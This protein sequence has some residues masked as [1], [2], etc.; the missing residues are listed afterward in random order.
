M[1]WLARPAITAIFLLC[2]FGVPSSGRTQTSSTAPPAEVASRVP[3]ATPNE[4]VPAA[5]VSAQPT[6]NPSSNKQ[7]QY[8]VG[9]HPTPEAFPFLT[10]DNKKAA[11]ESW[12]V[13]QKDHGLLMT[14]WAKSEIRFSG[15]GTVFYPFS[16]P[17]FVTVN[18]VEN[19]LKQSH[20]KTIRC[21]CFRQRI[22][23]PVVESLLSQAREPFRFSR[24]CWCGRTVSGT[25]GHRH[26]VKPKRKSSCVVASPGF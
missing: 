17:D 12:A 22:A 1:I 4:P 6:R 26:I 25:A 8:F 13:Y 2:A 14:D 21:V 3:A 24:A 19:P 20:R 23:A 15:A 16:G 5:L 11:D 7:G 18:Q 10:T 9:S